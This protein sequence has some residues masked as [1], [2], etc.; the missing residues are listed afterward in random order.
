MSNRENISIVLGSDG[1]FWWTLDPNPTA[2]SYHG[3]RNDSRGFKHRSEA[4]VAASFAAD[5]AELK[6]DK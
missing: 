3:T 6:G 2:A 1:G 4:E 5:E